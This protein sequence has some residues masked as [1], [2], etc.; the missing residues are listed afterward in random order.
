MAHLAKGMGSIDNP[1]H[2][3]EDCVESDL[4]TLKLFAQ[5]AVLSLCLAGAVLL[6]SSS[7]RLILWST[8]CEGEVGGLFGSAGQGVTKVAPPNCY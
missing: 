8:R 7:I 6:L 1:T 4:S 3:Q 2:T 5:F